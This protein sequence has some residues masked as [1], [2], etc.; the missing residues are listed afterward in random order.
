LEEKLPLEQ[1]AYRSGFSG[2]DHLFLLN[3]LIGD[4]IA[5]RGTFYMGLIDLR[6]AFPSVDRGELIRDLV[7]AGVSAKM[8]DILKKLYV[9]DTFQLLLDGVPG[10]VVFSVVI[11]VHEGSC[12][13]P[14]LFI[15]FIR[16]LCGELSTIAA[17]IDCPTVGSRCICCMVF[18][19]D[20]NV[21]ALE[22]PGTQQLVDCTTRFFTRRRLMPNPDKCEFVAI[23][24]SRRQQSTPKC[25]VE[26]HS[27]PGY[28]LPGISASFS[29][30]RGGGTYNYRWH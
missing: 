21:F 10:T 19:D 17:R 25:T 14:S 28:H 12:L 30:Q 24:G 11:G 29:R 27:D 18:A 8:V 26:G 6:K 2:T 16:D 22:V 15:F 7:Q 3:I 13:S 1:L 5:R 20:V 9:R 4:A 23:T